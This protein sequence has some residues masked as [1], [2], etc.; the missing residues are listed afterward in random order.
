[1]QGRAA[2]LAL[3]VSFILLKL[4]GSDGG[5]ILP[6]PRR[7]GTVTPDCIDG[8]AFLPNSARGT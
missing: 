1:M 6:D 4:D 7:C 2:V 5:E 8:A 3:P